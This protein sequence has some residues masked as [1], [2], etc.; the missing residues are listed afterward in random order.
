M[1][2]FSFGEL[3]EEVN[4]NTLYNILDIDEIVGN[5]ISNGSNLKDREIS[6]FFDLD[7]SYNEL[8]DDDEEDY[9]ASSTWSDAKGWNCTISSKNGTLSPVESL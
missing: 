3:S 7:A 8:T 2:G 4:L 1:D 5:M 6:G 9:E